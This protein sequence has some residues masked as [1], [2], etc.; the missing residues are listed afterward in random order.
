MG[1]VV[2][3]ISKT[4]TETLFWSDLNEKEKERILGTRQVLQIP[5]GRRALMETM[6]LSKRRNVC[7]ALVLAML[8]IL[9]SSC[10]VMSTDE[11]SD[12]AVSSQVYT[13][14]FHGNGGT[15]DSNQSEAVFTIH[16][17]QTIQLPVTMFQKPGAYPYGWNEIRA[18]IRH[19]H[20]DGA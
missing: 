14:F 6:S 9:S 5:Q 3:R 18:G 4:A 8:M 15:N 11:E 13:V 10:I 19:Q 2:N 1:S 17:G 16:G 20:E 7:L 12:G